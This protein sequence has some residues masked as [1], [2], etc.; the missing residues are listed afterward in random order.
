MSNIDQYAGRS[1]HGRPK[2]R[3][4]LVSSRGFAWARHRAASVQF[5][6]LEQAAMLLFAAR[7]GLKPGIAGSPQAPKAEM[8]ELI[9]QPYQLEGGPLLVS[10]T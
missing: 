7:Y 2:S 10:T 6:R 1:A 4:V 3:N 9:Q 5:H 8:T